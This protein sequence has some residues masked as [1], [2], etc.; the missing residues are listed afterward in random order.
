M[1]AYYLKSLEN[2]VFEDKQTDD[3]EKFGIYRVPTNSGCIEF[4]KLYTNIKYKPHIH[5][6]ASAT[7]YFLSGKGNALIG[8]KIIPYEAGTICN[9]PAGIMHGFEIFEDTIFLSVQSNPIQDRATGIID[10]RY[11]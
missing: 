10:I 1:T 8:E 5:D 11:E 4:V 3:E 9:A 2:I 6:F 7:F